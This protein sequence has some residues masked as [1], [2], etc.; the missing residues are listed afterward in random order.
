MPTAK[1]DV[2]NLATPPLRVALPIDLLPFLKV[3]VPVGVGPAEV[4]VAVKVTVWPYFDG[5]KLE[6]R[7]VLVVLR[8]N[9]KALP[10]L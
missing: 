4:T 10:R 8:W 3:T 2:V 9:S 1:V 5:F 6:A 7:A